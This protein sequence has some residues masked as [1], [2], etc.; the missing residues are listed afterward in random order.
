[1]KRVSEL[2]IT[3]CFLAFLGIG[4][5]ITVLRPREHISYY[6]NRALAAFP[7]PTVQSVG[8]GSF[9]SQFEVYLDDHAALRNS[10]L[11]AK[12]RLDLLL[13]RPVVNGIVVTEGPL[14]PFIYPEYP[15]EESI[16]AQAA[17]Y[18][19]RL[20][21]VSDAAAEYGG[22]F[23]YVGVPCQY[24]YFEDDYPSY[25]YNRSWQSEMTT[26][27]L[28]R[29]A[30]ARGVNYLDIRAVYKE[31]GHPDSFGSLIDNHYTM[32]GAFAA[33]QAI[34]EKIQAD[35]G[36]DFP[37]L[38]EDDMIF[39]TLP[40]DYMGSRERRLLDMVTRD[41]Q[42]V[43]AYPKVE[44]PFDRF[45]NGFP[46]PPVI[47]GVPDSADQ[48]LTYTMYMGGD[49]A[50]TVID[51]HREELPTILIYGDSFT[52]ALESV[53]YLSFDEMHSVDLRYYTGMSLTEYIREFQ[54]DIVIGVLD[55][56]ALIYPYGNGAV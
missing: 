53:A 3:V 37:I 32:A 52:N 42:L 26:T 50:N 24:S 2:F 34:M 33:Y 1:M 10:M 38:R 19:D 31:M 15:S 45:D 21:R 23:C 25:M 43:A 39:E 7:R 30:A 55:F 14:L 9:A 22:Y 16:N 28:A 8:D 27:A 49:I 12:C 18:A 17:A 41:E 40:N 47:N 5:A 46:S 20:K 29:E 48:S 51:T 44:V 6:E 36:L 11:F 56:E 13:H 35:T 54:P 4:L